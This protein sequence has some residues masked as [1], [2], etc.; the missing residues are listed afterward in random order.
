MKVLAHN[1]L[2]L[3]SQKLTL[4]MIVVLMNSIVTRPSHLFS[5]FLTLSQYAPLFCQ[6]NAIN[7]CFFYS[8][9]GANNCSKYSLLTSLKTYICVLALWIDSCP[10]SFFRGRSKMPSVLLPLI[11]YILKI[12][13][14]IAK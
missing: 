7:N 11:H 4:Y 10:W 14:E 2:V 9:E 13:N 1:M 6:Y 8:G 3:F 5:F 12:C